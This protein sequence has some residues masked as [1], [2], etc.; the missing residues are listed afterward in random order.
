MKEEEKVEKLGI[1]AI[2][3]MISCDLEVRNIIQSWF[4]FI[5]WI[6]ICCIMNTLWKIE[7]EWLII[8]IGDVVFEWCLGLWNMNGFSVNLCWIGLVFEIENSS[9]DAWFDFIG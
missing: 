7:F 1:F 6:E 5:P 8:R 4:K 2:F 9:V 3:F